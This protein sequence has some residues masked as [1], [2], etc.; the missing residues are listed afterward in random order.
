[1]KKLSDIS[2]RLPDRDGFVGYRC[3]YG[4]QGYEL[5]FDTK[6]LTKKAVFTVRVPGTPD[7]TVALAPGSGV[8][9]LKF[10]AAPSRED[11]QFAKPEP[12]RDLPVFAKVD[13]QL[14]APE[15]VYYPAPAGK[16]LALLPDGAKAHGAPCGKYAYPF[17][18]NF[19]TGILDLRG[20]NIYD[21]GDSWGFEV[22][23]AGLWDPAWHPEYGF[24][25]TYLA[26]AL[27]AAP[28]E[29][30]ALDVGMEAN[31]RLPEG[32]AYGRI[33]YVGGGVELR[34]AAGK[35]LASYVPQDAAHHIGFVA[36]SAVRFRL[37]KALLP[38]LG[39]GPVSVLSGA[40]D[41]HGGAGLGN[42]RP[43]KVKAGQWTGGGAA[44]DDG[45]ACRVYDALYLKPAR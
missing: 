4:A 38:G 2:L 9:T 28:G 25:L 21:E 37:P 10:K 34:D 16:P 30:A 36:D 8:K 23:M 18:P 31:F 22:K 17:D 41:D 40:Q 14:L 45:S 19:K 12:R 29:K 24:Q 6:E 43:V 11:W 33:I 7:R 44:S 5:D 26:I 35:V 13:Y 3:R 42:F 1:L 27:G 15:A 20:L 32:R 39:A